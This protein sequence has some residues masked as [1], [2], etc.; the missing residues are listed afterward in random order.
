[1]PRTTWKPDPLKR[2]AI[3]CGTLVALAVAAAALGAQM[4]R[5]SAHAGVPVAESLALRFHDAVDGSVRAEDGLTGAPI[6]KFGIGEGGFVRQAVRGLARD[7]RLRAIGAEPPF[8]L[9]RLADGKLV[10]SDPE[11]GR[12][13]ALDAFGRSNAASFAALLDHG[14]EPK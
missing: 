9:S 4:E 6:A 12:A 5:P 11:T 8:I 13:I 14:R 7:R 2:P 10:L 1:M 3:A